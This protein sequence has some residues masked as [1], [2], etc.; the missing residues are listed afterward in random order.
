MSVSWRTWFPIPLA[1]AIAA[2]PALVSL[3]AADGV[4]QQVAPVA[5]QDASKR[6]T[7]RVHAYTKADGRDYFAACLVP[8][9][10]AE[11][12]GGADVVVLFDTSASQVDAYR[13]KAL[14]SLDALL[15]RLGGQDRVQLIAVDL[16]GMS[17]TKSFVAP[18]SAEMKTALA[19]LR[20][21]TPL[22]AT[23]MI[24][25]IKAG[26]AAFDAKSTQRR[27]LIYI[28]D[29]VSNANLTA[30]KK[31]PALIGELVKQEIAFTP[32]SIGPKRN[33]ELL[34][35]MANQTGGM[36]AIDGTK[37]LA[38]DA[39]EYLVKAAGGLVAWP[40]A[41]KWPAG[42]EVFP[43]RP[44]P[45]RF[46][47]DTV[48]VG[49]GNLAGKAIEIEAKVAG[50]N[51]KF[52]WTAPA[53]ASND[54]NAFLAGLVDGARAD[55][56]ATLATLGTDGLLIVR[57]AA[58]REVDFIAGQARHAVATDNLLGALP[59]IDQLKALDPKHPELA[60][61][62]KVYRAKYMAREKATP[63]VNQPVVEKP[64]SQGTQPASTKSRGDATR[65]S[66]N[67]PFM[68]VALQQEEP[69][70]E[71]PF[72]ADQPADAPPAD[73]P[74]ADAP[75]A[76]APPADA[77]PADAAP[78]DAAPD[79]VAP[80]ADAAAPPVDDQAFIDKFEERKR[81]QN[82]LII[83][84]TEVEI[85]EARR[86]MQTNPTK[87]KE[88]M[89]LRL[90]FLDRAPDLY[91]EV[92]AQLMDKVVVAIRQAEKREAS[93]EEEQVTRRKAEGARI[94][95]DRI[96]KKLIRDQEKVR[97]LVEQFDVLMDEG[98]YEEASE[99]VAAHIEKLNPD[100]ALGTSLRE[101]ARAQEAYRTWKY[102]Y[103]Q[104][105]KRFNQTML[106][107]DTSGIPFPD[108]VPIIYPDAEFWED[109]TNR[110]KQYASVDL[111]KKGSAEE[112]IFRALGEN[113][114]FQLIQMPLRQFAEQIEQQH[115][116]QV[117]IDNKGLIDAGLDPE[118]MEINRDLRGISLR[119]AL[120]LILKELELT[121][122]VQ[123]EVLLI[124]T[125]D[126][127]GTVLTTKVYPVADLVLAIRNIDIPSM[128]LPF[129]DI[130][131]GLS[132]A[133]ADTGGGFG[134]GGGGGAGF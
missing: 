9:V 107:V 83:K 82:E 28:G 76:D 114:D 90:D 74:P 61:L 48:V 89:K 73:A 3:H 55:R 108:N 54:D 104:H 128:P 22:G 36:M 131:G 20:Q 50:R 11:A 33:G 35:T 2:S 130:F 103:N 93:F 71:D 38:A 57:R 59:L 60:T 29:G 49:A 133:G 87:A 85:S 100:T 66:R 37:F 116:I 18:Q 102:V 42:V 110:R 23:D 46:D 10:A 68:L 41:A 62:E 96:Q 7:I 6:E 65:S 88:D 63:A 101:N 132:T 17:L 97:Q 30:A 79:V 31:M 4:A 129:R 95:R 113:A 44:L 40:V 32:F 125:P 106:Q 105:V 70:A 1:A 24:A 26:M 92:R 115:K 80:P 124:T 109:L 98:S 123:N 51:V 19:R 64:R 58:E 75:P 34:A 15:A 47:R 126:K 117:E 111:Q 134:G 86:T 67:S 52:A 21:R 5:Q 99:S 56:G 118:T 43:E 12:K 72:G 13:D 119:S 8:T 121:Y 81:Q 78:A 77:P 39:G 120:R 16:A 122:V 69:P 84:E 14:E 127:A 94:E 45:L 25:A 112:K 27:A 53:A 91:P